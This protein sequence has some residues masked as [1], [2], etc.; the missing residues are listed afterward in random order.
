MRGVLSLRKSVT[1]GTLFSPHKYLGQCQGLI[2]K[3]ADKGREKFSS[4][5]CSIEVAI[6]PGNFDRL[7]Q[8]I[9]KVTKG[10][11]QFTFSGSAA[12]SS[13]ASSSSSGGKGRGGKSGGG[14][15]RGGKGRGKH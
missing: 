2:K 6:V 15:G 11:H 12:P 13:A 1:E 4:E 3:W 14:G 7:M 5:G 8:E 9:A 10:E